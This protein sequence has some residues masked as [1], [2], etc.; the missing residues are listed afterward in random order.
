MESYRYEIILESAI[1]EGLERSQVVKKLAALF[2]RDEPAI[3]KLLTLCP[4]IIRKDVDRETARKY[5]MLIKAAGGTARIRMEKSAETPAHTDSPVQAD[6][7][8]P[9]NRSG[10]P[11]QTDSPAPEPANDTP[12]KGSVFAYASSGSDDPAQSDSVV[13]KTAESGKISH[14]SCPRCGYSAEREDDVMF[15]RG[16][17]PRCGLLVR[18]E[19][20]HA[21]QEDDEQEEREIDLYEAKMPATWERRALASLYH[22]SLFLAAHAGFTLL[23]IF[24][25]APLE[26]V[27]DYIF[28]NFLRTGLEAFPLFSAVAFILAACIGVPL[29]NGGRTWAQSK[30]EI[31]LLYTDEAQTGGLYFSLI[32][33]AAA[34]CAI[35]F[36]PGLFVGWV[37]QSMNWLR[38]EIIWFIIMTVCAAL[39]WGAA[40]YYALK[41]P[42]K[43]SLLDLAA[44]TIQVEETVLPD[45]ARMMAFGLFAAAT[46][47]WIV[48]GILLPLLQRFVKF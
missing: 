44:G 22:F 31:S 3:D 48:L 11:V 18:K 17:C 25:F 13:E 34:I 2:K 9:E 36:V 38:H 27:G 28:R 46:G 7:A 37:A 33:R 45:K 42:D 30:F 26:S 29:I 15:V 43:R 24:L 5:V 47:F 8:L 40:C 20:A 32:F 19:L 10:Q 6:R 21:I 16:D 41:R 4:R 35:S 12:L 1:Q 39:S 14:L 23:C